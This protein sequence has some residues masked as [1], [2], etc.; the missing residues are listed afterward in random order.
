MSVAIFYVMVAVAGGW[1]ALRLVG[2]E[3]QD[4]RHRMEDEQRKRLQRE[5]AELRSNGTV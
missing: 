2:N 1:A 4:Q 5:I 3:R